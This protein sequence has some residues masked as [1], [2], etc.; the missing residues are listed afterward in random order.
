MATGFPF[1]PGGF[2]GLGLRHGVSVSNFPTTGALQSAI[3]GSDAFVAKLNAAGRGMVYSSY[4]GGS[5]G[6]FGQGIAVDSQ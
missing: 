6:D 3:A 4:L 5:S 1:P 2:S